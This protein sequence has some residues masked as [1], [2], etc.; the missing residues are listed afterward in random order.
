MCE[1]IKDS[2]EGSGRG[3]RAQSI[4]SRVQ[5]DCVKVQRVHTKYTGR[6]HKRPKCPQE[7]AGRGCEGLKGPR[8]VQGDGVKA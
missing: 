7:A 4:P 3:W 8:R 5:V 1:G 2:H 6:G